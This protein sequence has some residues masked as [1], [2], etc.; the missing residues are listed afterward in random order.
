MFALQNQFLQRKLLLPPCGKTTWKTRIEQRVKP[1]TIYMMHL[2]FWFVEFVEKFV[3]K[4]TNL[5]KKKTKNVK[6]ATKNSNFF[7]LFF[8]QVALFFCRISP[9]L[10]NQKTHKHHQTTSFIINFLIL[11]KN[12]KKCSPTTCS[13]KQKSKLVDFYPK[14]L[15]SG[16]K[17]LPV[18]DIKKPWH[19][20]QKTCFPL[21]FLIPLSVRKKLERFWCN[22][23]YKCKMAVH[24]HG[25]TVELTNREWQEILGFCKSQILSRLFLNRFSFANNL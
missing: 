7:S 15:F 24:C 18:W 10:T 5:S 21:N 13:S 14:W 19:T 6:K 22:K 2:V 17:F 11:K 1:D 4:N 12:Y 20:I 8:L 9:S 3:E 25:G 23:R 16:V